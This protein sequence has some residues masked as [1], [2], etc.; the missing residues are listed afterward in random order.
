VY[1]G[2]SLAYLA[3]PRIALFCPLQIELPPPAVLKPVP[4]WTGKQLFNVLLRPHS[5]IDLS[6]S[7]EMK[8]KNYCGV[9]TY[10]CK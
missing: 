8:A 2:L 10:M 3:A 7:F 9:G 6:A 4:L 5:G 1:T